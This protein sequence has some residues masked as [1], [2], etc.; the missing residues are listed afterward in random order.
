MNKQLSREEYKAHFLS[1]VSISGERSAVT[2]SRET[3]N[4]LRQLCTAADGRRA[5]TGALVEKIVDE[6]CELHASTIE[7]LYKK[8]IPY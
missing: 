2:I 5:S 3:K 7:E 1:A 6:H 4:K 8:D